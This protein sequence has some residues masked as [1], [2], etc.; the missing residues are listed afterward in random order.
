MPYYAQLDA[1]SICFAISELSEIESSPSLVPIDSFDASLIGKHWT[2][3]A[4][5]DAQPQSFEIRQ[6]NALAD[7]AAH[8]YEV[9]TGGATFQGWPVP[10]GRE[11]QA[12]INAAYT[13]ARDG[14]W[15]GGWK[16]AD[17]IYRPLTSEQVIGMALTVAEHVSAAFAREG[18]IAAQLRAA[19]DD[20]GL[21]WEW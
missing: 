13:L 20:A 8:R 21:E 3:I 1:Q 4:W 12:L 7:L 2:G 6:A 9:E 15:L 16:F 14:Y 17:G 5:G 11:S 10:T 18:Q 19:T